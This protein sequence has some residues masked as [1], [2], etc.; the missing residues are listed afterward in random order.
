MAA[1][2]AGAIRGDSS[3][4]SCSCRHDESDDGA[5]V[6]AFR[7]AVDEFSAPRDS[8]ARVENLL[9]NDD[10]PLAVVRAG[11]CS[12]VFLGCDNGIDS[13]TRAARTCRDTSVQ[14]NALWPHRVTDEPRRTRNVDTFCFMGIA[15]RF[16]LAESCPLAHNFSSTTLSNKESAFSSCNR[17][18][19]TRISGST[20]V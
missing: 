13:Q 2:V 6:I 4:I 5:I 17:A 3:Q 12:V 18:F 15:R 10:L 11:D 20:G 1:H 14:R 19:P 7:F 9:E 16:H 8:P